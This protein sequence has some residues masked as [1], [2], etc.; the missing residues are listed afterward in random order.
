MD[1]DQVVGV[2]TTVSFEEEVKVRRVPTPPPP[3]GPRRKKT[4][5]EVCYPNRDSQRSKVYAAED[6]FWGYKNQRDM[7]HAEAQAYVDSILAQRWFRSRWGKMEIKVVP[8]HH[9]SARGGYGQIHMPSWSLNEHIILH[10]MT[11]CIAHPKAMHGPL[12]VATSLVLLEGVKG[13]EFASRARKVYAERKVHWRNAVPYVPKPGTHKVLTQAEERSR[14]AAKEV[15]L[16]GTTEARAKAAEV[17]RFAVKE[18]LYGTTG[19]ESRKRAL[20]VARVL[21]ASS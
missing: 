6:A 9:G 17:I 11:H 13:K 1:L 20:A 3:G 12:F 5:T 8:K 2:R 21:E 10:E 4:R 14:Q 18:G 16:Y 15:K 7:S 19:S